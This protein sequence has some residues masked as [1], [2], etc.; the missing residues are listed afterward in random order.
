[1]ISKDR[2]DEMLNSER[3]IKCPNCFQQNFN[4]YYIRNGSVVYSDDFFERNFNQIKMFCKEKC[5]KIRIFDNSFEYEFIINYNDKK[6]L[7]SYSYY[8]NMFRINSFGNRVN[9]LLYSIC[10]KNINENNF[11]NKND[12]I[13]I[14]D[15]LVFA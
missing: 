1:M 12:A 13:K 3:K 14:I 6:Y 8:D 4:V 5:T 15:N 9:D 11:P 10:D 7:C 2:V